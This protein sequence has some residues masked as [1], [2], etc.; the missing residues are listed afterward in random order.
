MAS[1]SAS[2]A[3]ASLSDFCITTSSR[4]GK[5]GKGAGRDKDADQAQGDA[6]TASSPS[7]ASSSW[8][9]AQTMQPISLA[10]IQVRSCFSVVFSNEKLPSLFTQI[11]QNT[12]R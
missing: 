10:N 5:K 7:L 6:L 3:V 4:K 9:C 2:R 8:G 12:R 1:P 11:H